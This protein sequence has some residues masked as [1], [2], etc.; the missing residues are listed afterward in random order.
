[1]RR[2]MERKYVSRMTGVRCGNMG[3]HFSLNFCKKDI[4]VIKAEKVIYISWQ[5]RGNKY[6]LQN[7]A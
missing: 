6:E 4:V 5:E 7:R 1:M 2:Q 3:R